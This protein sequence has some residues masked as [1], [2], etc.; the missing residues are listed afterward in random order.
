MDGNVVINYDWAKLTDHTESNVS[1]GLILNTCVLTLFEVTSESYFNAD[2]KEVEI[3]KPEDFDTE[4]FTILT[5]EFFSTE[6]NQTLSLLGFWWKTREHYATRW[7][8]NFKYGK[9]E[10]DESITFDEWLNG[11]SGDDP[12]GHLR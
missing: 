3:D 2:S 1:S 7:E 9:F 5:N 8:L 4:E 10:W 6:Q 11:A 12:F